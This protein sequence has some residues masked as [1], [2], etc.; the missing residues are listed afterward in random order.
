VDKRMICPDEFV[1]GAEELLLIRGGNIV[2]GPYGRRQWRL[3]GRAAAI[4]R[5]VTAHGP[6]GHVTYPS[7]VGSH[8][9]VGSQTTICGRWIARKP[10]FFASNP[11]LRTASD[12]GR[13]TTNTT[14]RAER[15]GREAAAEKKWS[16]SVCFPAH[17]AE[18]H[19][20]NVMDTRRV[21]AV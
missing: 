1:T 13:W 16:R 19:T 6:M 18:G 3:R 12:T 4:A 20:R 10:I 17:S 2:R 11:R 8:Y 21:C 7:P 9:G 15:G 14:K 5:A